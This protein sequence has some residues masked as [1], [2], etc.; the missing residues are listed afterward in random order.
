MSNAEP[1]STLNL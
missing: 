1:L